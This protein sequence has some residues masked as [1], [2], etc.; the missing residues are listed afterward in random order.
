MEIIMDPIEQLVNLLV[1][2]YAIIIAYA[3][4]WAT[5]RGNTLR[6][7][8]LWVLRKVHNFLAWEDER[9]VEKIEQTKTAIKS[10]KR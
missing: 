3:A 8:Q 10:K 1:S 5:P 9:V 7:A 6:K 2:F 4:G